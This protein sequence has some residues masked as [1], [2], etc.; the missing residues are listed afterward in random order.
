MIASS[1]LQI[2][3]FAW[4]IFQLSASGKESSVP[5]LQSSLKTTGSTPPKPHQQSLHITFGHPPRPS[6]ALCTAGPGWL[7]HNGSR[8]AEQRSARGAYCMGGVSISWSQSSAAEHDVAHHG[9]QGPA[10][11]SPARAIA[12]GEHVP[13]SR[14]ADGPEG[15][16][17]LYVGEPLRRTPKGERLVCAMAGRLGMPLERDTNI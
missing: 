1:C 13:S 12:R 14:K 16:S 2:F 4:H 3:L 11:N 5:Q 10:R 15:T 6:S 7:H 17:L 9:P 8:S